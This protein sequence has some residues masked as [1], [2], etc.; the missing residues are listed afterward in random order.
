LPIVA[1]SAFLGV[2]AILVPHQLSPDG[3]LA[4]VSGRLVVQDGLPRHDTLA[5]LTTG[6]AWIDQQWLGQ[7]A[8][9]GV[10]AL[11]GIRLVLVANVALVVGAY[12]AVCA[13][14]RRRGGH[15]TTVAV[16]ALLLLLPLVA[17]MMI[18]R[19]QSL[20]YLPFVALVALLCRPR[21]TL[22]TTVGL[23]ALV[24]VWGNVHGSVLLAAALIALRGAV[25]L[26]ESPR[27]RVAWLALFTPFPCVLVSPYHVHLISYYATTA[28]NPSFARYLA[29]WAPTRFS[30]ISAPLL[31]LLFAVSWMLARAPAVYTL[32]ER[33]L[34]VVA[35]VLGLL[36][37]RQWAFAGLLVLML[38]PVGFDRAMR[39]RPPR[40]APALG[41]AIALAA[42]LAALV[43]TA[44]AFSAPSAK[45]AANYPPGAADAA[46][47]AAGSA[48]MIY[49]S[50]EFADWLLWERPDLAGRVVFDVRYE[51]LHPAEVKRIVLFDLGSGLDDPLGAPGVYILDPMRVH[52]AVDGLRPDV[53]TVYKTDHAVVA[54]ANH[55]Q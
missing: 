2:A 52:H 29:Q 48:P 15:P 50:E 46:A 5:A 16:T 35:V 4:L 17:S 34:L 18:V 22:P 40:A 19:T 10:A 3:W 14:A 32:Y 9:Y 51:L 12:L 7:V 53:R 6:R 41:A 55:A 44:G 26:R 13:Y 36:A 37:V 28:F 42:S 21:L 49:A 25:A 31:L 27:D 39:R 54:V 24:V 20:V 43:G 33:C 23:L 11:G 45:L 1:C 30:P 47:R 38:A 8:T